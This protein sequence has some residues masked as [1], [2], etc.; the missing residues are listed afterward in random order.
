MFEREGGI[1]SYV[2]RRTAERRRVLGLDVATVLSTLA[3][4]DALDADRE[5]EVRLPPVRNAR[6][7]HTRTQL[8]SQAIVN[9]GQRRICMLIYSQR[10][11][12]AA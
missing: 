7:R 5:V 10:T 6:G 1:I 8:V 2:L 9:T 3:P 11:G 12:P 4:D